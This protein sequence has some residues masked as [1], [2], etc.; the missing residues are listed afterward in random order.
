MALQ[1]TV[2]G[3]VWYPFPYFNTGWSVNTTQLQ[4]N[5]NGERVFLVW[6]VPRAGNIDKF[7]AVIAAVG[8]APD[9]GLRFSFQ[10]V[11]SVGEADGTVDQF[12]TVAS[13]SVV[14]G[15]LDPGT[16]DSSRTVARG[17]WVALVLDFPTFVAGDDVIVQGISAATNQSQMPY[18]DIA[19]GRQTQIQ[20]MFVV[21]YDDGEWVA[22]ADH[23]VPALTSTGLSID[24]G[25]NPDQMGLAFTLPFKATLDKVFF[26]VTY[27]AAGCDFDVILY[28]SVDTVLATLSWDG[29]YN[30]G[31][32]GRVGEFILEN[33]VE[34]D[35]GSL[36]RIILKPTTANNIQLA[37]STFHANGFGCCIGGTGFYMTTK[38][39]ASA[40][41][42]YND[43]GDGYRKPYIFLG[44]SQ[45]SDDVGGGGGG[46]LKL[47]GV[48]GLAG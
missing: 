17:D 19:T 28:D 5:A 24:S 4:M 42:D 11:D 31:A 27:Q 20:A 1:D 8:N 48:G 45:L 9:N 29:D 26:N 25:T 47:A 14:T 39:G 44:L 16:F 13:G 23:N 35:V 46:G 12:A 7:A 30:A 2:K 43:A 15:W 41:V 32:S 21:H 40:W 34:L 3:A 36:Y 37:Y 10:N 6:R 22:V 38:D 33:P 18:T